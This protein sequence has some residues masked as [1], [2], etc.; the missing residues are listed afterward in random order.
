MYVQCYCTVTTYVEYVQ[1]YGTVL[2]FNKH[3]RIF[4]AAWFRYKYYLSV[5]TFIKQNTLRAHSVNWE[6]HFVY[7]ADVGHSGCNYVWLMLLYHPFTFSLCIITLY[8][9]VVLSL[10][11][12]LLYYPFILSL[13]IIPLY[14]P[15]VLSIHC[16]LTFKYIYITNY[17][18][19]C[20]VLLFAKTIYNHY[21][22]TWH[23]LYVIYISWLLLYMMYV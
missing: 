13:C 12:V 17:V 15:F 19:A 18:F 21:I 10:Y 11:I 23:I 6:R 22:M 16:H 14:Y 1:C 4:S 2:F 5:L 3:T 9:P 20:F 7:F 8:C